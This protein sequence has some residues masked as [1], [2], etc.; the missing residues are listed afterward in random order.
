[1]MKFLTDYVLLALFAMKI[2]AGLNYE[3][4]YRFPGR[5]DEKYLYAETKEEKLR[6]QEDWVIDKRCQ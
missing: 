1:M 6:L 3:Y 2:A 4:V 5:A